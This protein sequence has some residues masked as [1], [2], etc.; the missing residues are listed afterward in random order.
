MVGHLPSDYISFD[1]FAD[2]GA[3]EV[4]GTGVWMFTVYENQALGFDKKH[5]YAHPTW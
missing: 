4:K 3:L 5:D 1:A 2:R